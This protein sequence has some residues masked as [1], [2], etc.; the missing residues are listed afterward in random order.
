MVL[1]TCLERFVRHRFGPTRFIEPSRENQRQKTVSRLLEQ[2]YFSRNRQAESRSNWFN[3]D[4]EGVEVFEMGSRANNILLSQRPTKFWHI[5]R[6]NLSHQSKVPTYV[7]YRL[8][9]AAAVTLGDFLPQ[10]LLNSQI[11]VGQQ[12]SQN[13]RK[14]SESLPHGVTKF[15]PLKQHLQQI[16]ISRMT[17]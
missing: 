5:V 9:L 17:G 7:N 14:M 3:I 10:C 12:F 6:N 4:L 1:Y 8:V 11:E 16:Y 15:P 2:E 13:W